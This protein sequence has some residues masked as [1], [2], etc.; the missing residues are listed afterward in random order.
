MRR[1]RLL[2]A[3]ALLPRASRAQSPAWPARSIKLIVPLAP[4]GTTNV[5]SR[6]VAAELSRTL[7]QPMVVDNKPG[8]GTVI[9]VDAAAKAPPDGH[10]L[11]TVANSF[12]VTQTLV[13]SLP[14][15]SQRDLQPVALMLKFDTYDTQVLDSYR[16]S[17]KIADYK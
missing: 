6:L 7:D 2:Q 12:C 17:I 10:T 15:D 9:G 16:T 4:G 11:V 1:R 5:V 3:G 8:A 13:K 14:Y